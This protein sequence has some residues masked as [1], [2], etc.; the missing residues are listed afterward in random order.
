MCFKNLFTTSACVFLCVAA[1]A[2]SPTVHKVS[3]LPSLTP[4]PTATGG[5]MLATPSASGEGFGGKEYT[6]QWPGSYFRAAFEGS[7]VFFRIGKN[8]EI[9]HIVVDGQTLS[10]LVKPVEGAYEIEGL[11]K[12]RHAV[13]VQVV[14]ESQSAPN[15][16]GGFAIPAGEKALTPELRH[17]QIEFIGDS[18]TVGYGNI[19][20]IRTCTEDEVW[21][22]TDD[23]QAFGPMTAA[24]YDADYQVNA[25]SGRGVV[26]NYNGFKGDTLPQAYPYVLFDKKQTYD[27]PEWKPQVL[28]IALGTNDFSTPLNP[29]E[30]WKTRD[31]LHTDYEAV[32]VKFLEELRARNP[33]AYIIV[34]ATDMANGEIEAEAGKVVRKVKQQGD[35]HISFL[36]IDGLSFGACNFH[37]SL[38]D[39][40][41]ISGKLA[42]LID[43]DR[44]FATVK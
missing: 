21:A 41:V 38:A 10:P 40:K 8:D 16:F 18:H 14:T 19:S 24:H 2:A 12:G 20:P 13:S 17:R 36:P 29:G 9:L 33:K 44:S 22:D 4:L 37:P 15:T 25:I 34:W 32:Y 1:Y 23:T 42:Q 6:S 30:P 39:E 27:D 11:S 7:R 31:E 5:R 28:V 26:R 3:N 43:A 35:Q